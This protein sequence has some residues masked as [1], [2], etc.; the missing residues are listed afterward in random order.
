VSRGKKYAYSYLISSKDYDKLKEIVIAGD[1]GMVLEKGASLKYYCE[2]CN[3]EFPAIECHVTSESN[4]VSP[5]VGTNELSLYSQLII[6]KKKALKRASELYDK[7]KS[8]DLDEWDKKTRLDYIKT[9]FELSLQEKEKEVSF[10]NYFCNGNYILHIC[11]KCEEKGGLEKVLKSFKKS[12]EESLAQ[13]GI[14]KGD[15]Q[16]KTRLKRELIWTPK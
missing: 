9:I 5:S 11:N 13:L 15:Y 3:P 6:P 16:L 14:Q 4:F 10:R 2:F 7:I 1:F 12:T 8:S